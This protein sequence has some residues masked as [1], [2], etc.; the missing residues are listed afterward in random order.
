VGLRGANL[1]AH[2][3]NPDY[4]LGLDTTIAYD[5]PGAQAHEKVTSLGEGAA[6][7]IMDASVICDPRMV[8]FLKE[9]AENNAIKWQPEIL[10]A[11]GTDTA[12]LQ[13]HGKTGSITGAISLPT[14]HLHQV[15]EMA[16]QEDID[17]CIRL[18]K[19]AVENIDKFDWK[20][21]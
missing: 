2:R 4:G 1:A 3:I 21:H 5:V 20:F 15:I 16:H 17:N 12:S 19:S 18:L 8:S 14:R 9:I 7:K 6:I 13:R 11:G 10:A